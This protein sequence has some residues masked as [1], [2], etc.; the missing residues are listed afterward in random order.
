MNYPRRL[1]L[2][3]EM[4][5]RGLSQEEV[6]RYL[7]LDGPNVVIERQRFNRLALLTRQFS[8][9]SILILIITALVYGLM[10]NPHDSLILLAIIIPSGLLTFIQEFRA[11]TTLDQLRE[12]LGS[13][14][15]VIRDGYESEISIE[16]IVRGDLIRLTAG[17]P[18][19]ADAIVLESTALLVDESVITGE[20][21]PRE[22][23][24]KEDTE[25]FRGTYLVGGSCLARV[26]RT[27]RM[28]KFGELAARLSSRD[29]VTAFEKGIARFG[30][31]VARSILVL[32]ILVFL[33]NLALD[34]PAFTSLLFSLALA[35]GLTPQMLPVIISICLSH[36]A[37]LMAKER[38]LIRRLDAIEDLG[39]LQVLCTDK[40]GTLTEGELA[41]HET[42]NAAGSEDSRVLA[43][44]FE[45]AINQS[46][47]KGAIRDAIV[48]T[49][50]IAIPREKS[51][52]LAFSFDRRY[53]TVTLIDGESVT[54]GA[55]S[56]VLALC[57]LIRADMAVIP[58]TGS[59]KGLQDLHSS[60]TKA[61]F[62]VLA[63]ASTKGD[64][65]NL[66]FEGFLVLR[67]PVKVDAKAS[68]QRLESLGIEVVLVTGDNLGTALH[69]AQEVGISTEA[70][71]IG[72]E[73]TGLGKEEFLKRVQ[74]T[75]VFAEVNPEQ[76][77]LIVEALRQSG[78]ATGFLGDG[79][80]DAAALKVADVSISVDDASEIAKGASSVVLLEKDLSVIAEGV[81]LGRKTFENTMKYIKITISASFGNVLS[82]ALASFFLPFLPL[83]PTQILLLNFLS[84]LPAV[85]IST[86][87]VDQEQVR[88]PRSWSMRGLGHFM[89]FFGLISTF[90]DLAL[91]FIVL[92]VLG[93]GESEL[94]PIWFFASLV[95]EVIAIYALRTQGFAWQSRPSRTLATLCALVTLMTLF[96]ISIGLL[97]PLG[98]EPIDPIGVVTIGLLG[99]GYLL[100]TEIG[101]RRTRIY[102]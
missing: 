4:S 47:N 94:R 41:V 90:F 19:P 30:F 75:R 77:V 96:L 43:L 100:S 82:M 97:D 25:L 16:R 33:G 55:V 53:S 49:Q 65:E 80:N 42:L 72:Q 68:V 17:D 20:S 46:T 70:A 11:A 58:I 89:V 50:A 59:I 71:L 35:V 10:G 26:I 79:I 62:K 84:D 101:K 95:T 3:Q 2:T 60:K 57:T 67:D 38:V 32:V 5:Y 61:G 18:V 34:R 44:A 36:G 12:R 22:K 8:S 74:G 21:L 23:G 64:D 9:P 7:A 28:T 45:N 69:V 93:G 15:T 37:R 48:S 78:R 102:F 87:S 52:E 29:S 56:E 31:F 51:S 39:S 40:T 24:A 27:G 81:L 66:V 86:D 83:L 91:F 99:F 1:A 14:I 13:N 63:I 88:T 54:M 73:I 76:K 85:A 6:D 98:L 92:K